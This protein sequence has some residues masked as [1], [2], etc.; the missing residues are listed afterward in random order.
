MSE[1]QRQRDHPGDGTGPAISH[2]LLKTKRR[3]QPTRK[4]ALPWTQDPAQ[5]CD[6]VP[7]PRERHQGPRCRTREHTPERASPGTLGQACSGEAW[8]PCGTAHHL[9]SSHQRR[10]STGQGSGTVPVSGVS[11]SHGAPQSRAVCLACVR[12]WVPTSGNTGTR[13]LV[14]SP[15]A[16]WPST[17]ACAVLLGDWPLSGVSRAARPQHTRPQVTGRPQPCP[18]LTGAWPHMLSVGDRILCGAEL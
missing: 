2:E 13:R 17:A 5:R 4:L 9:V 10:S 15:T 16:A 6:G 14:I 1:D 11:D 7:P 18:G 8:G 12:P 3:P